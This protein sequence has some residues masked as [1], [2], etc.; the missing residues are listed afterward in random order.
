MKVGD[1]VRLKPEAKP[2]RTLTGGWTAMLGVVVCLSRHQR[3]EVQWTDG[4]TTMPLRH[5]V[6]IVVER[7]KIKK[8]ENNLNISERSASN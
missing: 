5:I 1:L 2:S 6:D 4:K 8:S 7:K 3:C